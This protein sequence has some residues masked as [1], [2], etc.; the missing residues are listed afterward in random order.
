MEALRLE[1][2]ATRIRTQTATTA[3]AVIW[4]AQRCQHAA[5]HRGTRVA[6]RSRPRSARCVHSV[7]DRKTRA[8]ATSPI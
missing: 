1:V 6:L 8:L 5:S 4:Y 3:R 2:A 7:V